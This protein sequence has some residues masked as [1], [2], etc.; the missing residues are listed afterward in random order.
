MAAQKRVC[1]T[2]RFIT[3]LVF[4]FSEQQ[5]FIALRIEWC[6]ARV[7]A[8]RWHEE[9]LLLQEEM[10]RVIRSHDYDIALWRKRSEGSIEGT[11]GGA[12]AYALR[13]ASLRVH[14]K[15]YCER[16]WQSVDT[17]LAIG[18]IGEIGYKSR[19]ERGR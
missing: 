13:Q 2:V 16:A 10:Q 18:N 19:Q 4:Q 11:S 9:C 14:M 8:Q 5:P 17:W 1:K 6:K 15:K 7:R 12:R 3:S